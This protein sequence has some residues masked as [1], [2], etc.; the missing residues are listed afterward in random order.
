MSAPAPAP[1]THIADIAILGD[2][3]EVADVLVV[4]EDF[5]LHADADT[6]EDL[7]GYRPARPEDPHAW[8]SWVTAL[9]GEHAAALRALTTA[10]ASPSTP[11]GAPR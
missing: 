6:L 8:A 3:A 1:R 7:A 9:L 4:L 11:I 5:L 10:E 2:I